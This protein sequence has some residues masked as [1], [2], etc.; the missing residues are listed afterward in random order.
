MADKT[1]WLPGDRVTL[2]EP[3]TPWNGRE[4]VLER[5][6]FQYFQTGRWPV[7]LTKP[8]GEG[9]TGPR[10]LAVAE[11]ALVKADAPPPITSFRGDHRFL[12]NFFSAPVEYEGALYPT[13]EHAYQAAKTDDMKMREW[14]R[15]ASSPAEAKHRGQNLT[16]RPGW[17]DMRLSVME[18]LLKQK[19][20]RHADLS[21]KLIATHPCELR[22]G[23][24]W[25]DTFWGTTKGKG[26]NHLGKL[27]MAIRT[28]ILSGNAL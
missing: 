10:Q 23:N 16:L 7:T 12:S 27:L 14:I 1:K 3:G 11:T 8:L 24:T 13:V 17:N 22:E 18:A 20:T 6:S 5:R 21:R 25:G 4:G 28:D 19:F 26:D 2:V 15:T 9:G